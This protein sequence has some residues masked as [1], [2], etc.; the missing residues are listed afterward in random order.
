MIVTVVI[1][2]PLSISRIAS[3]SQ[4]PDNRY[5]DSVYIYASR[6]IYCAVPGILF[7]FT[8]PKIF[9]KFYHL[10]AHQMY[11][12]VTPKLA[13]LYIIPRSC[14]FVIIIIILLKI[15]LPLQ[16]PAKNLLGNYLVLKKYCCFFSIFS[17]P[18]YTVFYSSD[19]NE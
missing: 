17:T 4:W 3:L 19:Y 12:T 1:W 8:S 2:T 16:N 7:K 5:S 18:V 14:K 10:I 13:C 9:Q 15:I 11:C 6:T